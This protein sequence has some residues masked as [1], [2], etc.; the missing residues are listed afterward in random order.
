MSLSLS[1]CDISSTALEIAGRQADAAGVPL[2]TFVHDAVNEPL[3]DHGLFD[4]VTCSLFVHHLEHTEAVS[5]LRN[6]GTACGDTLLVSDLRRDPIG[7]ALAWGASRLFTRSH[8]VHVDAVKSVRAALTPAEMRELAS[9]AGL[10]GATV[11]ARFP[12]RMLLSWSP[13]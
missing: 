2:Q 3:V 13:R 7:L 9:E 6:A 11:R 8:I 12:R 1:A 10:E 5:L 4:L